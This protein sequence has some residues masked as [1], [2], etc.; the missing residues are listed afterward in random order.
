VVAEIEERQEHLE[1]VQNL[2][3]N[4]ELIKNIK[5]EIV[6]R[7]GELQRIRELQ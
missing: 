7:V 4:Q 5:N 3:G 2:G 1:R 6:D